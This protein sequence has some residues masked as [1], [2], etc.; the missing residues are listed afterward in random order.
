MDIK[1]F[2]DHF[3]V[4]VPSKLESF[5]EVSTDTRTLK[6]GALFVPLKGENFNGD[7]FVEKALDLGAE[8]SLVSDKQLYKSLQKKYENKVVYVEDGLKTFQV[9][10]KAWQ[11]K[12]APRVVA[13]TGSNGKTTSKFFTSQI[14]GSFFKVCYS[15]KSFNNEVGVPITQALLKKGD[16][17]LVAEV[18]TN[19]KGE[20]SKL[21]KLIAPE[22]CV[23]TT[24]GASHLE[25]FGTVDNVALEKADIYK[26]QKIKIGIFNLDNE[27]T[28][29]MAKD[30]KGKRITFSSLDADA[31]VFLESKQIGVDELKLKGRLS[32][33]S[34]ET[35]CKIFGEHNVY[36]IMT[37][38][39]VG[40]ALEVSPQKLIDKV[41][42][43]E[44]PW[45][46]SQVLETPYGAKLLFDGYNSNMQSMTALFKGVEPLIESGQKLHFI[47]GEMLELGESTALMHKELGRQV[48]ALNPESILF[49]GPS[50]KQFKEGVKSSGFKKSLVISVSYDESLAIDIRNVLDTKSTVVVKG[51][52]GM[53]LERFFEGFGLKSLI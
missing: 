1:F 46:R 47:L 40:L 23:V 4:S 22:I 36:N 53:K 37:A 39:A 14:L 7:L 24:V 45:G 2:E 6:K 10:A 11:E 31:D 16:E 17:V 3:K 9:L 13:I 5:S 43:I 21:T 28:K 30:F 42:C 25:G 8:V 49:I 29:N 51:S 44:T 32:G 38:L 41:S 20:I 18:G 34:V 26:S 48:G 50:F 35:S 19:A 52:R 15:P 33:C 27:W 12:V